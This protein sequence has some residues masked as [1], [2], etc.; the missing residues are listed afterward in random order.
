MR[1]LTSKIRVFGGTGRKYVY[2]VVN[3]IDQNIC[4]TFCLNF[5]AFSSFYPALY[6]SKKPPFF[7][8]RKDPFG[9]FGHTRP[10]PERD[11]ATKYPY[12]PRVL[13]SKSLGMGFGKK[14]VWMRKD[15]WGG[16]GENER[17]GEK[18]RK[19]VW[20]VLEIGLRDT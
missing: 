19:M 7:F 12:E 9:P 17:K 20:K 6:L 1:V 15:G 5:L 11:R 4:I 8:S 2:M 13:C 14:C 16:G 10:G 18:K 3:Y